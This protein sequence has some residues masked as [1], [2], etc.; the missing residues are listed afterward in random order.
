MYVVHQQGDLRVC[1]ALT[2]PRKSDRDAGADQRA[3]PHEHCPPSIT[4]ART[5]PPD[6]SDYVSGVRGG[7]VAS[8]QPPRARG[9]WAERNSR[10]ARSTRSVAES[11][12]VSS[13]NPTVI[14]ATFG[15]MLS[16]W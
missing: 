14:A 5:S 8:G 3:R 4:V 12:S 2:K 11:A 6:K 13:A 16:C 15:S 7:A 1:Q 9:W 10:S